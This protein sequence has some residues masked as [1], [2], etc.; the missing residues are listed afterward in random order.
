MKS[1]LL[2]ILLASLSGLTLFSQP[3]T[4]YYGCHNFHEKSKANPLTPEEAQAIEASKERSDTFD[5]IHYSLYIDAT[6]YTGK[7]LK[8]RC[9]VLFKAKMNN[10]TKI[11]FDFTQLAVDSV[12]RENDGEKVY[13]YKDPL[14]EVDLGKTLM[15]GD[16]DSLSF[17]YEGT[18]YQDPVWGG[19]YFASNIVYN[20]G[21]GLSS[22]PP[23][24]GRVW[25][26][27][28]D[29]FVE[30]ATY[31]ISVLS[32]QGRKAYSIGTFINETS[33]GGDSIVRS[34]RMNQQVPTYLTHFAASNYTT[35]NY[36]YTSLYGTVP[37]QYVA[38]ASDTTNMKKSFSNI[39]AA[40]DCMQSWFGKYA[41]E[42]IGYVLTTQGAMEHPTSIAYPVNS[43]AN[44]AK[45]DERI[46]AH[47]FGHQ[48]WGNIVTLEES[49]DMWIKEG[50]AEYCSHLFQ[51]WVY[52]HNSFIDLVKSNHLRILRF[53]H[54]D[55]GKYEP[56][57]GISFK[58]IYGT[59]SYYKG[60]SVMH[61]M[62]GYMGDSLY[63]V[64][65]QSILTNYAYKAINAAKFRD[66]LEAAT[67][68]D[69]HP[70]FDD[71]IYQPG[72][73]GFEI[74]SIIYFN[75]NGKKVARVLIQQKI[76][77]ANH[78]YTNV[79][80]EVS[81][82]DQKWQ[83]IKGKIIC[84][85]EFGEG[86][87]ILPNDFEPVFT[88]LNEDN[89]LNYA[90]TQTQAKYKIKGP[91]TLP[92]VEFSI[93][94]N[95]IVD[96]ALLSVEHMWIAPDPIKNNPDNAKISSSHYWIVGGILPKTFKSSATIEYKNA[97]SNA[98]LDADLV[99][100]TE[101]SLILVYRKNP[102]DDWREFPYYT[103]Q[104]LSANDGQG[105]IK[106]DSLWLGEYAFANG[107]LP[108]VATHN[109]NKTLKKIAVYPNPSKDF[110]NLKSD[111]KTGNYKINVYSLDGK[112]EQS[113]NV[114]IS[115]DQESLIIPVEGLSHGIH[116]LNITQHNLIL[117]SATFIKE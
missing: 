81:F 84:S 15:L 117:A 97:S 14:I 92:Y 115:N 34:Y 41:W 5:I 64:G 17:T 2:F 21:I 112:L 50:N 18:P 11:R 73:A 111:F 91:F 83:R 60:A 105:F 80:L 7:I 32:N 61:N 38:K 10:L 57:S 76:R 109:I 25:Y 20:L 78:F 104:K 51:D 6:N 4:E 93:K 9:K 67:G 94:I 98:Y 72:F 66:Q 110:L 16:I 86:D 26:P 33:L 3:F 39:G 48:W 12:Y 63:K 29:N 85:G 77:A 116:A 74:D 88:L 100:K 70:F 101:D 82:Y 113:T 58:N 49:F 36:N 45:T 55:D 102:K 68:L 40:L 43:I 95:E 46:M 13:S 23:N 24:F 90:R 79:P 114:T 75:I 96:T 35:V 52:G 106:I 53:A 54:Q 89:I 56:L 71:Q 42:R 59:H 28:F 47:E 103:K 107:S 99:S 31:D 1:K 30:T 87:I 27:C 108:T 37:V 44:G 8:G 69:M 22:N 62:R 65:M 19:M